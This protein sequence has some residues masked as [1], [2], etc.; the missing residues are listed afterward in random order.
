MR[1]ILLLLSILSLT[2]AVM[3]TSQRHR[4]IRST[5]SQ[6]SQ[7]TTR[8]RKGLGR[9]T[10]RS[11]SPSPTVS[12]TRAATPTPCPLP[13]VTGAPPDLLS[14]LMQRVFTL[15]G[16]ACVLAWFILLLPA[17]AYLT[18]TWRDRRESLFNRLS[19]QALELYYEQFPSPIS[20]K[21]QPADIKA[22]FRKDFAHLYGLRHYVIPLLLLAAISAIG[23]IA[24]FRFAQVWLGA[25]TGKSFP[26]IAI[27]AFLGGY[28]WVLYD[29]FRRF[30]AGDFTAHDVYS[31]VYRFLI[32]VPLGIS[33]VK[34]SNETIGVG[35]AF[36]LGAFPTAT[37]LKF[38]RRWVRTK[39]GIGENE[40]DGQLELEKLQCIGRSNAERY[41]DEGISTIAELAWTNPIELTI[42]TNR[43]FNFVIDS[44]SQALMWVYFEDRVKELYPLSLRGAQEVC[45]LFEELASP[46]PKKKS[47]AEGTLKAAAAL[48]QLDEE[49][50]RNTLTTVRD[51]PYAQF[52]FAIWA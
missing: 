34:L 19:A 40:E 46:E 23:F 32:V 50:F 13:Q 41:L 12:P 5:K 28:S 6:L 47:A 48:M 38:S 17:I 8:F 24:T 10:R 15:V 11:P 31:G 2:A 42:R 43:D 9:Q 22:R 18:T 20:R 45:T 27:S 7:R 4:T 51:D 26:S 44:I 21:T 14:R 3:A 39:I 37:L 36:L 29:Q 49:S 1:P 35:L 33:L 52:L 16:L 30:R 25:E